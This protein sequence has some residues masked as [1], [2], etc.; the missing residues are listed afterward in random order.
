MHVWAEKSS[1]GEAILDT[2]HTVSQPELGW[3]HKGY[4][5]IILNKNFPEPENTKNLPQAKKVEVRARLSRALLNIN[6]LWEGSGDL[7]I[8]H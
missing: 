5:K 2:A 6:N 4:F 7:I 1:D 3:P 8:H